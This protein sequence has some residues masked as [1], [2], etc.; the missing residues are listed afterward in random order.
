M[1]PTIIVFGLDDDQ[2]D[3]K[4]LQEAF[5]KK[6]IV[7]FEFFHSAGEFLSVFNKDI[8]V[9]VVD[10]YLGETTGQDVLKE[11]RKINKKCLVTMIS[12]DLNKKT[13]IKL[14]NSGANKYV[15]KEKG[16][17]KEVAEHVKEHIQEVQEQLQAKSDIN[18]IFKN[19]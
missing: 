9:A 1:T 3:S 7:D 6:G 15:E 18:A 16:W 13:L 14:Y 4:L 5:L 2:D 19:A 11:I 17:E 10:Y 12:G 8:H